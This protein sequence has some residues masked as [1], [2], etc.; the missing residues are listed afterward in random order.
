[1]LLDDEDDDDDGNTTKIPRC[2]I[3]TFPVLHSRF[4]QVQ[5]GS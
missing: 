1:M 5:T 3:L 4:V 2:N